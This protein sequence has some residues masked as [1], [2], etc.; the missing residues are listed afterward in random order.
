[1]N[2]INNISKDLRNPKCEGI[3]VEDVDGNSITARRINNWQFDVTTESCNGRETSYYRV[4]PDMV[5][6][7]IDDIMTMCDNCTYI[8]HI[9]TAHLWSTEKIEKFINS[10]CP[11]MCK[12]SFMGFV[13]SAE[14]AETYTVLRHPNLIEWYVDGKSTDF[15]GVLRKTR[16]KLAEEFSW[17]FKEM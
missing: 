3:F 9:P 15:S 6:K 7:M 10:L 2:V 17:E 1:M 13:L 8:P 14:G 12:P 11:Q 16:A 4:S 5:E